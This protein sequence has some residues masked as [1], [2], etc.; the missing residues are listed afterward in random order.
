MT[1]M[2][3]VTIDNK[4]LCTF[5]ASSEPQHTSLLTT[6]SSHAKQQHLSDETWTTG[7]FGKF[8]ACDWSTGWSIFG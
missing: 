8:S 3:I 1:R 5:H 4:S 7:N 6:D 2:K